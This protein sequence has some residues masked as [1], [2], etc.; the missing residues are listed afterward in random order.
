M[1]GMKTAHGVFRAHYGGSALCFRLIGAAE[2]IVCAYVVVT[3][4]CGKIIDGRHTA[5]RFVAGDLRSAPAEC[6]RK[7]IL[8]FVVVDPYA[9]HPVNIIHT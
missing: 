3:A 4:E 6:I 7:L 9:D 1:K 8:R 2:D 5:P